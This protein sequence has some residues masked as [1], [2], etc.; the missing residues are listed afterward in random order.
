MG[1]HR[2]ARSS[3]RWLPA[4]LLLTIAALLAGCML[5]PE[6]TPEPVTIRFVPGEDLYHD[7]ERAIREFNEEY[8][9]ITIELAYFGT[10]EVD[11]FA[12]PSFMLGAIG[13]EIELAPLD[14]YIEQDR[15]FDLSD[16]YPETLAMSRQDGRTLAL[17]A[18]L[19]MVVVYY[20]QDLFDQRGVPYPQEGWTLD[21]F[22]LTAARLRDPGAD[23][24]GYA[25]V[26]PILDALMFIRQ[27]GGWILDD[28]EQPTQVT[29][30]D[31]RTVEALEFFVDL[32]VVHNVAPTPDQLRSAAFGS[33]AQA[34]VYADKVGMWM[35]WLSQRGGGQPTSNWPAEWTMR[36]G[37]AP[38][39]GGEQASTLAVVNGYYMLADSA[40]P[41]AAWRWISWLSERTP[42]RLV[43]ARRSILE[44]DAYARLVGDE[45]ARVA[46]AT[47]EE[48]ELL[49][50]EFAQFMP[51]MGA[52]D[53]AVKRIMNGYDTPQ[54]A[55]DLAQRQAESMQ[56]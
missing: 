17:P 26:D 15:E 7:Y 33:S 49:P 47:M 1:S 46:L 56:R 28:L 51:A 10:Q 13:Q 43:P 53:G 19:D 42:A 48:A 22:V 34:G 9:H 52:L 4:I 41:E 21:D 18:G 5:E 40:H 29:F 11:A 24:F 50:A 44:S 2:F 12:A 38:L 36:W 6:P 8:P 37:M 3:G 27:R 16:F 55:L 39:P 35:D 30:N 32:M 23:V 20:S 45:M 54:E 31:P 14:A 25:A